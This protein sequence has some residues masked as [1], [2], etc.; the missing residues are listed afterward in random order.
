VLELVARESRPFTVQLSDQQADVL[1]GL[2][3]QLAGA[4]S[5]WGSKEGDTAGAVIHVSRLERSS[6]RVVFKDVVG[7]VSVG[8]TQIRIMPKIPDDHFNFL[9]SHST[10]P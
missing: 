10:R 6:W 3:R 2:G 4:K 9:A 7:V 1:I 5:W 8:D